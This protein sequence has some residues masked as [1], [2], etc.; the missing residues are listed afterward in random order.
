MEALNGK[1]LRGLLRME[2]LLGHMFPGRIS[3]DHAEYV[4]SCGGGGGV[5]KITSHVLEAATRL[6]NKMSPQIETIVEG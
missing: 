4:V 5:A 2:F 1:L 6:N 3:A